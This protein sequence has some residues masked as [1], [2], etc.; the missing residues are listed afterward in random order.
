MPDAQSVFL[1][2]TLLRL[3]SKEDQR[4]AGLALISSLRKRMCSLPGEVAGNV[5]WR[6]RSSNPASAAQNRLLSVAFC[7]SRGIPCSSRA[8]RGRLPG[9]GSFSRW[10]LLRCLGCAA[11]GGTTRQAMLCLCPAWCRAQAG[12]CRVRCP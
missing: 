8:L 4:L 7:D 9:S 3:A 6:V 1:S 2:V 12:P 11:A 5:V 10:R